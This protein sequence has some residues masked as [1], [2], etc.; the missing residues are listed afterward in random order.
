MPPRKKGKPTRHSPRKTDNKKAF[1]ENL[2]KKLQQA[3]EAIDKKRLAKE[4]A[5][6]RVKLAKESE[7]KAHEEAHKESE[8]VELEGPD[9]L[10]ST[11]TT[12]FSG[13]SQLCVFESVYVFSRTIHC[14]PIGM[15][16]S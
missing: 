10:V 13:G 3:K 14:L 1:E 16:I 9:T 6:E 8:R 4:A 2:S 15:A 11:R 5:E 12:N 7:E